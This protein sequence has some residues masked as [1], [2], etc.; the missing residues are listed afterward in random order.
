MNKVDREKNSPP[1][2]PSSPSTPPPTAS[3]PP[4]VSRPPA[5]PRVPDT[6]PAFRTPQAPSPPPQ[7]SQP[8]RPPQPRKPT[9][10][11]GPPPQAPPQRPSSPPLTAASALPP[12]HPPAPPP[13]GRVPTRATPAPA[14]DPARPDTESEHVDDE[15]TA[16]PQAVGSDGLSRLALSKRRK[17]RKL[18]LAARVAVSLVSVLALVGTGSVW[19]YLRATEAGFSQ[20]AA[21]DTESD[22]I[23]DPIG[24][25]GDETYLIV[26]T[27]TR[28]GASGEV[29]AGSIDDAEGSRADVAILVNIPA[30]RS[31]VVAVSFPRDLDVERPVC[32]AWDSETG[33]YSSE[34]YPAAEGDKLNAVY[35]LGGP[36]CLVKTIQKMSGLKIG[37]FVGIDF[38]GFESMVDEVGG[39]E[40]CTP[41]PLVDGELGTIIDAA[42]THLLDGRRAL[43]YVRARKIESEINSDYSRINRQQK[44]LSSLLRSALSNKVLLDPGK[45]NGL[46]GAFTRATFVENVN[47]DSL[48]KLGRSLQNVDAGAVTFLT[49]PT[50]GTTE[51]G[52]EIPRLDDIE[53][54]FTAIIDD[55]P[56][57]GEKRETP[58][59]ADPAADPV[60]APS[61][62][63]LDP[64][65]V[66]VR[67]SNASG[68]SGLAAGTAEELAAYGFPIYDVGNYTGI[69]SQTVVRFAPGMEAEAMTVASAFPGA[70][71]QRA[72][73][74]SLGNVVEVVLGPEFDGT[75][76]YPTPAG[77]PLGTV[78]IEEAHD[79]GAAQLPD[80]LAVTNAG[81]DPC[82]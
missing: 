71:L 13:Q 22:D 49:T 58:A 67:V 75:L 46:I 32:L 25:T 5:A 19:S 56:L 23:V 18:R 16:T 3:P 14:A 64:S 52:N 37:H 35:A 69:S 68:V 36:K 38:A 53:A 8:P 33:D 81:A 63:A 10:V 11:S 40:V 6:P 78:T 34:V 70:V 77:S 17:Q 21:L 54:I 76:A 45:L 15:S 59:E 74:S 27:D 82:S 26:G 66:S 1:S 57:P 31:R 42:G 80:D 48:V 7:V 55:Q 39:V 9:E 61:L 2:T 30:D 24:Q 12:A 60:V 20:I 29:G 62:P 65:W 79:E 73:D 4:S 47:A 51:W 50:A 44:F 28:A 72:A 43:D 41:T